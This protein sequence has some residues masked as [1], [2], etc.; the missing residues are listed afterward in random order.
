MS[1]HLHWFQIWPP[2]GT[3]CIRR[4]QFFIPKDIKNTYV[5][6]DDTSLGALQPS[7]ASSHRPRYCNISNGITIVQASVEKDIEH[8]Y[9]DTNVRLEKYT[10]YTL[11]EIRMSALLS[12]QSESGTYI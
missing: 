2:S 12:N 6:A 3:T 9:L 7:K 10:H 8:R 1:V 4:S 5:T 11:W